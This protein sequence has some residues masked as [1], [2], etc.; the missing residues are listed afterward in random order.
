MLVTRVA[1]AGSHSIPIVVAVPV[2]QPGNACVPAN[3]GSGEETTTSKG[4]AVIAFGIHGSSTTRC[5]D[6]MFPILASTKALLPA[7]QRSVPSAQCVA[8]GAKAGDVLTI[9]SYG[10]VTVLALDP[11][12]SDCANGVMASVV[13][14]AFAPGAKVQDQAAP[15]TVAIAYVPSDA[16]IQREYERL[17][18]RLAPVEEYHVRHI[19][20]PTRDAAMAAL[21]R[22]H[23]GQP[24]AQVAAEVTQDDGS[25]NK[26]GDL[27]WNVPSDFIG[28]FS[29]SMVSLAPSGLAR[30]PVKTRF[31]WHV[32]E[33]I[34]TKVGKD[35]FPPLALVKSRIAARLV[36]QH[37]PAAAKAPVPAK[38]VCRNMVAPV[39]PATGGAARA[40]GTVV[41]QLRVENG[42]VAQI[43]KLS[44]P[45]EL[46]AVVTEAVN[47]YECDR[48]DRPA[49]V[50]QSFEF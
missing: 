5:P 9:P 17:N 3:V 31:G 32:I 44:G 4:D 43:V 7:S 22:I 47:K 33:V 15:A 48:L 37:S 26:G 11:A 25:K 46:Y 1:L 30:E 20:L 18:A 23:A 21:D 50:V 14:T 34:E 10:R 2:T 39:L 19:L 41:A 6:P 40:K 28:E 45:S 16:D 12:K 42:R 29:K 49:M 35:S 13:A 24:F 36:A 27:G 38:A 8:R